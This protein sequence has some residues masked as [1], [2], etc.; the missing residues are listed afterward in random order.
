M[1]KRLVAAVLTAALLMTNTGVVYAAETTETDTVSIQSSEESAAESGETDETI[2]SEDNEVVAPA[3]EERTI[4]VEDE[5]RV[6]KRSRKQMAFN[7]HR[8][9]DLQMNMTI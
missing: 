4:T 6:M 1:R 7:M 3:D 9:K 8:L 5:G 2:V